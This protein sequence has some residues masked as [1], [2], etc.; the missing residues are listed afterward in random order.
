M[1]EPSIFPILIACLVLSAILTTSYQSF[2]VVVVVLGLLETF[3]QLG[4]LG[5]TQKHAALPLP[6]CEITHCLY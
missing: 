1:V 2:N 5:S 6:T 3:Q 4:N